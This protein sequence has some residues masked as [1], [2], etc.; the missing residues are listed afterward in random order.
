MMLSKI[1]YFFV[2]KI[3]ADHNNSKSVQL[4]LSSVLTKMSSENAV[5][6][7]IG[8]G[9]TRLHPNIKNI[10]IFAGENIDIVS[11]AESLPFED[12]SIDLIISQEVLEHVQNPSLAVQEM[13]R[14]LKKDGLIYCQLP[15]VIGY[16]PGPTDFW[17]FTKEGIVEIFQRHG[18]F[19]KEVGISVGGGTGFYRICVEFFATFFSLP[20]SLLYIPF[21]ILFSLF[22]YPI[23][24]LDFLFK[25]SN[26]RDRI[27][28]GYYII[29][30]K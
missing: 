24:W 27:S 11:K 14:V 8:A 17:R 19:I 30:T 13:F 4:A 1:K 2:K 15:F 10:D 26:Q 3:Y 21:K 22:F 18:F 29:T 9:Y 7:N 25:Y 16:H 12:N 5:G 23:K 28:G 6:I 20:L